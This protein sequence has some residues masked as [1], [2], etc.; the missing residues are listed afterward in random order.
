[1]ANLI[2][3]TLAWAL[4]LLAPRT[5]GRHAAPAPQPVP[6]PAPLVLRATAPAPPLYWADDEQIVRP[7]LRAHLERLEAERQ[8]LNRA[9]LVTATY[10]AAVAA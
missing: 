5:P 1:M 4:A 7:Y 10:G 3:R 6:V 9:L 8:R 2:W